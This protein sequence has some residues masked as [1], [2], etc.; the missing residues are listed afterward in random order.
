MAREGPH[1]A[2]AGSRQ[3]QRARCDFG[4]TLWVQI[5]VLPAAYWLYMRRAHH[6]S[7]IAMLGPASMITRVLTHRISR[8][9]DFIRSPASA[10]IMMAWFR[11]RAAAACS[12]TSKYVREARRSAALCDAGE[13][14][15]VPRGGP[16]FSR[17]CNDGPADSRPGTL[18]S[19]TRQLEIPA[20]HFFP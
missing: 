10:V 15:L 6:R 17:Q 20:Y 13:A 12:S 4:L 5:A 11:S 14:P 18:L 8:V 1:H 2:P 9:I 16:A 19:V 3:D 7:I